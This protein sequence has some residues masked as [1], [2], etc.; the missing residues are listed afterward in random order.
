MPGG[1]D[2]NLT[3][4]NPFTLKQTKTTCLPDE[5]L[6][7]LRTAWN[8]KFPAKKI[9]ASVKR[10]EALWAALRDRMKSQFDCGSEY[11]AVKELG[12]SEIKAQTAAYFRPEARDSS[13][14]RGTREA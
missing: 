4:C 14:D 2:F 1:R 13:A 5:M 9:P 3:Q 12:S 10:K 6:E 8:E 7:R 11:C